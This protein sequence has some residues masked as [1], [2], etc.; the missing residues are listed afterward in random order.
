MKCYIWFD[1]SVFN[2][3]GNCKAQNDLLYLTH[4]MTYDAHNFFF[5]IFNLTIWDLQFHII[6]FN[7][8]TD[9]GNCENL[10]KAYAFSS[11]F[12]FPK[13]YMI[14]EY[15]YSVHS[16]IPIALRYTFIIDKFNWTLMLDR[17]WKCYF[18]SDCMMLILFIH[19]GSWSRSLTSLVIHIMS[20]FVFT[21]CIQS[22]PT[23][24]YA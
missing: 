7:G 22:D 16:S 11:W 9:T 1:Y 6:I 19:L 4:C 17:P 5:A 2:S 3:N 18:I 8:M 23:N 14:H 15:K 13:I 12:G 20:V 24:L 21:L 10:N